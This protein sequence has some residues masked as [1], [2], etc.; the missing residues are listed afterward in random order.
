MG[1]TDGTVKQK[2]FA[3]RYAHLALGYGNPLLHRARLWATL[4]GL[5]RWQGPRQR[6]KP[7]TPR[8]L[9]WL[10][11]FLAK[12]AS[13][14][15]ADRAVLWAALMTGFF[16]MLRA[17]EYL[18]QDGRSWSR[19]RVLHGDDIAPRRGGAELASFGTAEEV[20]I[21]IKGS[22]T[23]QYNVGAI[24]NQ[25]ATET[26]LC[27][28]AAMRELERH[29]PQR[30]RGS[31]AALPI[32]RWASG[33]HVRREELQRY[34]EVAA[35]AAGMEAKE[36]GSHSLRI[37]GATSMYHVVDDLKRV[38]RFGRWSTDTFHIYLWES[39]EPMRPVAK[40]MAEDRSELTKP[41]A[42]VRRSAAEAGLSE[43]AA[44]ARAQV[45]PPLGPEGAGRR[46]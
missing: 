22:K 41:L 45:A 3:V 17:S 44:P 15:E 4:A 37:G 31:E 2:L 11:K 9:V 24:R 12:E 25:Y 39:H 13:L 34:I 38:Q 43:E 21:N 5:H 36:V 8:M 35:L 26:E 28:V 40:G 6:K 32:F 46:L 18:V 30:V 42:A 14:S 27:P 16:F 10:K 20:V 1:R 19:E 23:D 33:A 29:F 7:V